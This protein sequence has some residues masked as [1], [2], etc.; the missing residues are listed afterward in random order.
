MDYR[1][2]YKCPI[3]GEYTLL[4]IHDEG[5][6]CEDGCD[7]DDIKAVEIKKIKEENDFRGYYTQQDIREKF[8]TDFDKVEEIF[9]EVII[10]YQP[11]GIKEKENEKLTTFF[12]ETDKIDKMLDDIVVKYYNY[13]DI[14]EINEYKPYSYLITLVEDMHYYLNLTCKDLYLF[15]LSISD[16]LPFKEYMYSGRFFGNNAIDHLFQ[17]NER[18][19]VILGLICGY[20][21]DDDLSKNTTFRIYDFLKK[22][23]IYNVVFKGE[24]LNL[25]SNELYRSLKEIRNCNEHDMSYLNQE[26]IKNKFNN[27]DGVEVDKAFYLPMVKNI[28]FCLELMYQILNKIVMQIDNVLLYEMDSFPMYEQF[29]KED[30]KMEFKQYNMSYYEKLDRYNKLLIKNIQDFCGNLIIADTYFRLDEVLHCIR[31]IYNHFNGF[32]DISLVEFGDFIGIDY[33]VYS[34]ITRLYSCYDKIARYIKGMHK[35]YENIK[36]FEDFRK[37]KSV[38]T[39]YKKIEKILKN[40]D[41]N[42]L[43]KIRNMIYHNLRAGIVFGE[44]AE[45]YYRNV[46]VQILL[47]NEMLLF[48]LLEQIKPIKKGKIERNAL[49]PCGSGIKYKKCHGK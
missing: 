2:R 30:I 34:S 6:E 12:Y 13:Y 25:L 38:S 37:V 42:M 5:C 39:I 47:E 7:T 3:C 35:E 11:F 46:L 23:E 28:V 18:M 21:F 16:E 29:V 20:E 26:V 45:K 40:K 1:K 41:Y 36:Y 43:Q 14:N 15:D 22:Q 10:P 19:Y 32:K 17:A 48:E 44:G 8:W 4:I 27:L 31:D 9:R 24:V 49:C 33:I